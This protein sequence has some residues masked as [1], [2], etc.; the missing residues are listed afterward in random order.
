[1]KEYDIKAIKTRARSEKQQKE[2][3]EDARGQSNCVHPCLLRSHSPVPTQNEVPTDDRV[4]I[5]SACSRGN[6][7]TSRTGVL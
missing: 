2:V 4:H 3:R 5:L 1:M 7:L 6:T